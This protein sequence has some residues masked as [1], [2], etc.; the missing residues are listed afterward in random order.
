VEVEQAMA[1]VRN[2]AL[3]RNQDGR[4]HLVARAVSESDTHS[5]WHAWQTTSGGWAG[6]ER[7]GHPPSGEPFVV[8]PSP[9]AVARNSDGRLEAA[10]IPVMGN[11]RAVWHAW[12]TTPGGDWTAWRSLGAPPEGSVRPV[13]L[14]QNRD[15]RLELFRLAGGAVWHAWQTTP[16]EDWTGWHPLGRPDDAVTLQDGAPVVARNEDGRLELFVRASDGAV[17]H[18]WQREAGTR[19]WA[20]WSSLESPGNQLLSAQFEFPMVV[21]NKDGRLELFVRASD[22]TIW[23]RRQQAAQSGPWGAWR[24][25]GSMDDPNISHSGIERVELGVGAH[26]DGRL[27]VFAAGVIPG[28]DDQTGASLVRQREQ[29]ASGD[30]APWKTIDFPVRKAF[31]LTVAS[32]AQGRLELFMPDLGSGELYRLNQMTP[33]GAAWA[34]SVLPPPP[35]SLE[36]LAAPTPIPE[37]EPEREVPEPA[38]SPQDHP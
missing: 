16:G 28:A 9:P 18:R 29:T 13:A 15:G 31:D 36:D 32:D 25:L 35:S 33:N 8:F 7:L 2:V 26:A 20:A 22:D 30:W 11:D 12:Q 23:H 37:P 3:A 19:P 27:A 10:V 5:V 38:V 21:R 6:W 4:L 14:A 1:K 24:S 34:T 17:W